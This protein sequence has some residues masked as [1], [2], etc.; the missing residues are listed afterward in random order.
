MALSSDIH[1]LIAIIIIFINT[2]SDVIDFD[3]FG[4]QPQIHRSK[5]KR[6]EEE[7]DFKR[8]LLLGLDIG[9]I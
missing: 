6:R 7:F 2:W 3:Q 5:R 1:V 8:V 4:Y 9:S